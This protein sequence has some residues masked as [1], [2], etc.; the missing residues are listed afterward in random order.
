M[1]TGMKIALGF[2]VVVLLMIAVV[3]VSVIQMSAAADGF[4]EYRGLARDT[5]L[6]GRLQANMLMVR[7]NVKD[8]LITGSEKDREEYESYYDIMMGFLKE[9]QSEIQ[10]PKRAALIDEVSAEVEDYNTG[11]QTVQQR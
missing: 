3:V 10:D 2:A 6:A 7:M 8:F 5:N 11:F 9:A 4:A 1:K